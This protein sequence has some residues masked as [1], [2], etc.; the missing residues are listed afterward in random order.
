MWSL[1][2]HRVVA[3]VLHT[4]L[5][6]LT[7]SLFCAFSRCRLSQCTWHHVCEH[8]RR[9]IRSYRHNDHPA[10]LPNRARILSSRGSCTSWRVATRSPIHTGFTRYDYWDHRNGYYRQGSRIFMRRPVAERLLTEISTACAPK[11]GR[12]GIPDRVS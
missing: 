2:S 8:T 11:I 4:F 12:I 5:Q 6:S 9:C 10:Y 7:N 3:R 1:L